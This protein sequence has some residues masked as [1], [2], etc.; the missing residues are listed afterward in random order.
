MEG[1]RKEKEGSNQN[2]RTKTVEFKKRRERSCGG[3]RSEKGG[4]CDTQIRLEHGRKTGQ[5]LQKKKIIKSGKN[6]SNCFR[7]SRLQKSE[8]RESI[9]KKTKSSPR[10][11]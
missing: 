9:E 2:E 1:H 4:G 6:K 5:T 7:W 11:A 10:E 3:K 8:L